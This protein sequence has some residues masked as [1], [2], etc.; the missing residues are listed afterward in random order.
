MKAPKMEVEAEEREEHESFQTHF[1]QPVPLWKLPLFEIHW[2]VMVVLTE[3]VGEEAPV[4]VVVSAQTPMA[5]VEEQ[6]EVLD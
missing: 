1:W 3:V 5:V 4:L 6:M 2:E